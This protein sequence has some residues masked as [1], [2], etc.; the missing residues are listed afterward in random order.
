MRKGQ[1]VSHL[2][3]YVLGIITVGLVLMLG[4]QAIT[5]LN[6]NKCTVQKTQFTTAL[7]EAIDKDKG[8]GISRTEEFNLPCGGE[9][10][11]FVSRQ[12]SDT[13]QIVT[14]GIFDLTNYQV[15]KDSIESGDDVNVFLK[16][17]DGFE[18]LERFEVAAPISLP[19][20][21]PIR[22]FSGEPV[23]IRFA[24]LGQLVEPKPLSGVC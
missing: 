4:F 9:A 12:S 22:C 23:K 13:N 15:I 17:T 21:C 6:D 7:S 24:G 11:C 2:F 3:I 14:D 16:T 5:K 10:V 1:L 8:W 20:S 19:Q 18:R